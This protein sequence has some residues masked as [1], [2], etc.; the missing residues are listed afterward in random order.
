MFALLVRVE[1]ER[2]TTGTLESG[3]G[4]VDG[5][6]LSTA[7][8]PTQEGRESRLWLSDQAGPDG[9]HMDAQNTWA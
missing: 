7:P 2:V 3:M 8:W 4:Q 9:C 1:G 6:I 5:K